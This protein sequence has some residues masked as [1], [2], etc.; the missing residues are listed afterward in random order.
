M[1]WRRTVTDELTKMHLIRM[2]GQH[3]AKDREWWRELTVASCPTE[4]E[5]D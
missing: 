3:A 1:N 2:E 4:D 5:E